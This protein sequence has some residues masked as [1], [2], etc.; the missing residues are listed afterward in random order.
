MW[1]ILLTMPD[2]LEEFGDP[3]PLD[4]AVR[5]DE[6]RDSLLREWLLAM[7]P[8]QRLRSHDGAL[9][10]LLAVRDGKIKLYGAMDITAPPI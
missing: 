1:G 8:E 9:E 3:P 7:T 10:W 5:G 4:K 2:W 6:S